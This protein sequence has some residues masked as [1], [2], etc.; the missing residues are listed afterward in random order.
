MYGL[1]AQFDPENENALYNYAEATRLSGDET[2]AK[3]LYD[4]VISNFSGSSRASEAAA[5][6][7]EL[8]N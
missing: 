2:G 7:A 8:N 5:R 4:K 1:A 6:I 3:L